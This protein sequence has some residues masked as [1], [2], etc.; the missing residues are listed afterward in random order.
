M[1]SGWRR[2]HQLQQ[3]V[4]VH[5]FVVQPAAA[6]VETLRLPPLVRVI[7]HECGRHVCN[8]NAHYRMS[9]EALDVI[10]GAGALWYP[11]KD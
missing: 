8:L 7:C 2:L 9:Q 10:G 11:S 1:N 5:D 4:K 3:P 6:H